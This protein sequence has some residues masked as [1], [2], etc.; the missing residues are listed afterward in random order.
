[1]K[2]KRIQ[3]IRVLAILFVMIGHSIILYD[4]SWR[5]NKDRTK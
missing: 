2:D 3:N 1:M 4:P 5:S